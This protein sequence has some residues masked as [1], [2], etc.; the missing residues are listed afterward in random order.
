MKKT[1][2]LSLALALGAAG[3]V[4]HAQSADDATGAVGPV[5]GEVD[6]GA[7]AQT[8]LEGPVNTATDAVTDT[9]DHVD[10]A[11]DASVEADVAADAEVG[12]TAASADVDAEA[13]A[14]PEA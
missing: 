4:A 2:S 12:D 13:E 6:V 9:V 14:D 5:T 10:H 11:A 8:G 1:I 3:S 7:G